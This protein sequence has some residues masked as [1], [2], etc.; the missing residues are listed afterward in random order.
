MQKKRLSSTRKKQI[1]KG[2]K[3]QA[4][5]HSNTK[6][7]LSAGRQQY[8]YCPLTLSIETLGGISTS[9]IARG[10]P[11]PVQRSQVFS[12]AEDNQKSV[13]IK[14]FWGERPFANKNILI[15]SCL[16]KD[17]P[18]APKATPQIRV[19]FEIDKFCHLKVK[20]AEVKSGKEIETILDAS[21][22]VLTNALIAKVLKQADDNHMEDS[23]L[24]LIAE[25]EQAI[26]KDREKSYNTATIT[27][28]ET[29]IGELGIAL[30]EEDEPETAIK[31]KE[32]QKALNEHKQATSLSAF[33][34]L[35]NFDNVFDLF[36]G[37]A[38]QKRPQRP[39]PSRANSGTDES[40]KV[41]ESKPILPTGTH[42]LIQSH[43]EAVDPILEQK[44]SGAWEALGSGS[45]DGCAQA[46]HS[47][48]EVLRQLLDK[49][50]PDEQVKKAPWYEKPN[51]GVTVTRAM[52]IRYTISGSGVE[53][54][55]S[56]SF[57]NDLAQAV[58]SMYSKLSAESHSNRKAAITATHMYLNACEAVIGLI[59]FHKRG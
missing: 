39:T 24:L 59:A 16:L 50:A 3:N 55:S 35:G 12:T 41:V 28:I 8:D 38:N 13:E 47:M 2:H 21:S 46:A 6:V 29:L 33:G 10:T 23:A 25:S 27:K 49:L 32:L 37:A 19:T 34:G 52:R 57:I 5:K 14:A 11:L 40:K 26:R 30:S 17:I 1:E 20:A 36:G 4:K 54:E 43:L 51:S 15:G 42:V 18:E 58:D 7:S 53:S 9:L 45:P 48:R 56:L 22:T 44:R 31:S